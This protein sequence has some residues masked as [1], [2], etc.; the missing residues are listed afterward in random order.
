MRDWA[1]GALE[2]L[3]QQTEEGGEK[4]GGGEGEGKEGGGGGGGGREGRG[5]PPGHSCVGVACVRVSQG[6]W[7]DVCELLEK[8]QQYLKLVL[9]LALALALTIQ[10]EIS[11]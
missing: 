4:E 5:L 6:K 9:L 10:Y 1:L 11:V 2:Q 7:K 8:G 3:Q